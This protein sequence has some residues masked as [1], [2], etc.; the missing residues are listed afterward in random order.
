MSP[1]QTVTSDLLDVILAVTTVGNFLFSMQRT[2][3]GGRPRGGA[4]TL[5]R[6]PGWPLAA[7]THVGGDHG[8]RGVA[9]RCGG[10]DG[11]RG[12]RRGR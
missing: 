9:V 3:Q 2:L 6:A 12:A 7:R 10:E 5:R 4:W 1:S 8:E 11:A